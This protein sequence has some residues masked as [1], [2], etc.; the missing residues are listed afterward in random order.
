LAAAELYLGE[1]EITGDRQERFAAAWRRGQEL[2]AKAIALDPKNGD[3]YLQRAYLVAFRDLAAAELD[4]QRGLALSPNSAQGYAG[5]AAVVYQNPARRDE[6]L[7]L[8]DRARKLDPLEPGYDVTK[9]LFL[10]MERGDL[11]G[12][13]ALLVDVVKRNPD[14]LPAV[15]RL[16]ELKLLMGQAARSV[17]Y[18]EHALALDPAQ[19]MTRRNLISAYVDL[20]DLAAAEALQEAD[21]PESLPRRLKRLMYERAWREAGGVAYQSLANGTMLSDIEAAMHVAAIRMHARSTGEFERAR[22]VLEPMSGVSWDA[23]GNPV[24][25]EGGS[26]LRDAAVGLADVLITS[27]QVERGQRLL[28]VIIARMKHEIGE[29]DRPEFWFHRWHPTALALKG[30]RE[31]ALALMERSFASGL[32]PGD[33]W[34]YFESE[35]AF[36]PLRQ[37][38]RFK[39]LLQTVRERAAAQR[40]DLDLM[41][42]EKIVPQ[43][44][45]ALSLR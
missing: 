23:M 38:V 19:E 4:Y 44:S 6:T 42:A 17:R 27:G 30:E 13:D 41:R 43:R 8:L 20:G 21:G 40:R 12:S 35:P 28:A 16:A 3:A 22:E 24:L 11:A 39:S 45:Q 32:G 5:L 18:G 37:D 26:S 25:A 36:A 9:A 1:Y 7:D 34:Y 14:Y 29:L 10:L 31:A 15:A 33:W 2:V